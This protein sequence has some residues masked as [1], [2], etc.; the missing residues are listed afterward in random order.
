MARYGQS[1]RGIKV[2]LAA[3]HGAVGCI[4]YFDPHEDGYSDA[5]VLPNRTKD[6]VQWG[7]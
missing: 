6:G 7:M 1:F 4:I 2:K 5:D 3:E